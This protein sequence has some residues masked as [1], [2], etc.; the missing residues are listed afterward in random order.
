[1]K[2]TI[3]LVLSF[4]LLANFSCSSDDDKSEVNFIRAKFNNIDTKFN[5]INVQVTPEITDPITNYSYKDIIVTATMNSD[6]AKTLI[7][8]SEF[9]VTGSNEIWR[10]TYIN[11]GIFYDLDEDNFY[12]EITKNSDGKYKGTF[13]GT[14]SGSA[15]NIVLTDGIFDIIYQ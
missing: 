13:Y 8:S 9:N 15:E 4:I 14:L 12:S 6:A 1:M 11:N 10:F 7:I 2:K 3:I 5:I